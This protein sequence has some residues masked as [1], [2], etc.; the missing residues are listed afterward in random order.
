[1]AEVNGIFGDQPIELNNAATE[2]TLRELVSAIGILSAKVGGKAKGT[3]DIEKELKKFHEAVKKQTDVTKNLTEEEKKK[4]EQTKEEIK[5]AA[6]KKKAE[7]AAIKATH[8]VSKGIH[9]L[10]QVTSRVVLGMTGLLSS[11]SNVGNSMTSAAQTM[12][13]IP[14][15]GGVLAGVFGAV[16]EAS[17]KLLKAYQNAATVGVTFGGSMNAMVNAA[18]GAGLTFDQF[19]GIVAKNGESLAVLGGTAERG[20]KIFAQV[21]K[22]IRNS[23]IGTELLALG[24]STEQVNNGMAGYLG[25]M[26]RTGATQGKSTSELARGASQYLKEL[27]GL[28]KLTG[29]NREQLQKEQE[30]RLKDS[31]FRAMLVGKTEEEQRNIQALMSAIPEEHKDAFKDMLT[32]GN[33]TSD[34]AVKFA[35]AMPGAAQAAMKAGQDIQAGGKITKEAMGGLYKNYVNEAKIVEKSGFYQTQAMYNMEEMGKTTV[36]VSEAAARSADGFDKALEDQTKTTDKAA[37]NQA[38]QMEKFKQD[39]AETSNVFTQILASSGLLQHLQTAFDLLV[40]FT[41][42]YVV[43]AFMFLADNIGTVITVAAVLGVAFLAL[44]GFILAANVVTAARTLAETGVVAILKTQMVAL[45]AKTAALWALVAPVLAAAAP[46]IAVGLAVGAAILIFRKLGGDVGVVTDGLKYMWSGFKT[47][48]TYLK[49]GFYKVL[50]SLPGVDYG[51][52]IEETQ[53]EISEQQLERE[54]LATSMAERMEE[55]R[56]RIAAEEKAEAEKK[57]KEEEAAK[58]MSAM[59]QARA[60]IAAR[61]AAKSDKEKAAEA[62]NAANADKEKVEAAAGISS[63]VG[64]GD[65]LKDMSV[66]GKKKID[67]A[68]E[69]V[70]GAAERAA[71]ASTSATSATGTPGSTASISSPVLNQDQKKNMELVTAA[72]KKQGLTD[73]KYIAATLGNVM[74]E[75]GGKSISENMNYAGTSNDRIRKIFGSRAAGKSDAELDTIKKDP[76]QMGEMMYG[77]KTKLGQ[78]MGNT[79]PGDGFKYRG[80]GFIQLTGKN[81]YAAASKAIYGDDRLVKNPDL[82]NDPAVAAEV[83]AWYMKKGQ[84]GMAKKLGIDTGNMS[85]ADANLLATS[86]IAG[87][88]I[89]RKGAIGQE[90]SAK[91]DKYAAGFTTGPGGQMIASTAA[92][93]TTPSTA[94][95]PSQSVAAA[96]GNRM[97]MVGNKS[98]VDGSPEHKAALAAENG[99]STATAQAPGKAGSKTQETA[100]SLLERLNMQVGEL[101]AVTKDTKRVNERQLGVMADNSSN[102]YAMGA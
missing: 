34:A 29:Q 19:A 54:K 12:N 87:G 72:L 63:G 55:N 51:T 24:Y 48:L 31:Q 68:S 77:S 100:E 58:K 10:G 102:L 9:N 16:A 33:M 47:F 96:A 71:G 14:V 90:I 95:T 86:Q 50:D 67:E 66:Y 53:K 15:V 23:K 88:D 45:A 44:Q 74:K 13:A 64:T 7:E 43:P 82:V 59:D 76:S 18:S 26:S 65:P 73:P 38:A 2:A 97:V 80:R 25:M 22:E 69:R 92:A 41:L 81:N 61:E 52:E 27:D 21:G 8:M 35:A 78:Q 83:S 32:T 79:E 60:R 46:F 84:T 17:E 5:R 70:L 36:G 40:G 39:L 1:M 99:K 101:I 28:A 75:T 4:L 91:V 57:R 49:L 6:E 93:K 30:A 3:Q 42:D 56:K 20:A 62:K 89:R 85:Q 94:V 11:L 98:Y 37:T